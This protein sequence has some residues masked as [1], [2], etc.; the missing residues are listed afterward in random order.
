MAWNLRSPGHQEALM[1]YIIIHRVRGKTLQSYIVDKLYESKGILNWLYEGLKCYVKKIP[2]F[3]CLRKFLQKFYVFYRPQPP[4]PRFRC[5]YM[6]SLP[7]THGSRGFSY[8]NFYRHRACTGLDLTH[9]GILPAGEKVSTADDVHCELN[10][11]LNV[12]ILN[13]S[14][15]MGSHQSCS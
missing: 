2:V 14:G 9:Y 5:P 15:G 4:R 8:R 10:I 12:C 7:S 1:G 13:R 11:Y 3:I 6:T